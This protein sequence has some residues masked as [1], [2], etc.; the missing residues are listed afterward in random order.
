MQSGGG[1]A[2]G[3]A[4]SG[5]VEP[6]TYPGGGFYKAD[7]A[8]ASGMTLNGT[9][10]STDGLLRLVPGSLA[11]AGTAYFNAAMSVDS[12]TS[13]FAHFSLRAGGGNGELGGDGLAFVLQLMGPEAVGIGGGGMGAVLPQPAALQ[14]A[15][16][17]AWVRARAAADPNPDPHRSGASTARNTTIRWRHC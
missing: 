5:C 14:L 16:P 2:G 12:R 17:A 9:A 15:A 8:D 1:S 10:A 3:S 6:S 4:P 7:I 13:L 11:G